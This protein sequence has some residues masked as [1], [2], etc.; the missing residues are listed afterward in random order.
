MR[1]DYSS[2]STCTPLKTGL[3]CPKIV[4]QVPCVSIPPG[5]RCH[6]TRA[7]LFFSFSNQPCDG[8]SL[9]EIPYASENTNSANKLKEIRLCCICPKLYFKLLWKAA[10]LIGIQQMQ[11]PNYK[12]F[13]KK[14]ETA[15]QCTEIQ[16]NS[17]TISLKIVPSCSALGTV[18]Q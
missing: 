13:K 16:N 14:R 2:C 15:A 5:L 8:I 3:L 18:F 6:P 10:H 9:Y 12:Q 4:T 17:T 11:T 1:L 7:V